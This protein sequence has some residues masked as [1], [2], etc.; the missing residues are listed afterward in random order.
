MYGTV[1][2]AGACVTRA[3]SDARRGVTGTVT[4]RPNFVRRRT[5]CSVASNCAGQ[6]RIAAEARNAQSWQSNS[7]IRNGKDA[8]GNNSANCSGLIVTSRADGL[9]NRGTSDDR[10]GA[11]DRTNFLST[12]RNAAKRTKRVTAAYPCHAVQTCVTCSGTSCA[13]VLLPATW[14]SALQQAA[15][16]GCRVRPLSV[17]GARMAVIVPAPAL[18]LPV[19]PPQI[20]VHPCE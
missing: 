11:P 19:A 17:S 1:E 9:G 18:F 7:I 4:A 13:G 15:S 14:M 2:S 16:S 10:S 6:K 3:S 20:A 8:A 12:R 5:T